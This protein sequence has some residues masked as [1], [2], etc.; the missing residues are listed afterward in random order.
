[1]NNDSVWVVL[2]AAGIGQRMRASRPKQY[3][4]LAGRTVIEHSIHCFTQRKDIQAIVVGLRH[5]DTYWPDLDIVSTP[6]QPA[7]LTSPGCN[8]RC[9][10]VFNAL[11]K[12]NRLGGKP[13]DWV[14]V[15]DAARPCL[16][17]RDINRLF[18]QV[19]QPNDGQPVCGGVLAYA[20]RDTMKRQSSHFPSDQA[21]LSIDYTEDRNGLWHALT[22]QL[23][24]L[25]DLTT[26]IDSALN[27]RIN[28]TDEA[29]AIEYMGMSPI[30][31]EGSSTNIK[32]TQPAD[33]ELAEFFLQKRTS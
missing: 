8:E 17:Q 9:D 28:I 10:T 30:L 27:N 13:R 16:S 18:K 22:P 25:G 11:S 14:L 12:I 7:I 32:I 23:F 20:V 29:S 4:P 3:L 31:V 24:R 6:D 5:D 2:P 19:I 21:H 15:H 33:L 1:M 26:A